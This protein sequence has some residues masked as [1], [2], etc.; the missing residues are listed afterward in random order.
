MSQPARVVAP[1]IVRA[2]R[3]ILRKSGPTP[4]LEVSRELIRLG[5]M[6]K[7]PA[8]GWK[9]VDTIGVMLRRDEI[10]VSAGVIYP[11]ALGKT[12]P[13]HNLLLLPQIRKMLRS[14]PMW[15][16]AAMR[17]DLRSRGRIGQ[18]GFGGRRLYHALRWLARQG[19][20]ELTAETVTAVALLPPRQ[21]A[22]PRPVC[23]LTTKREAAR[24]RASKVAERIGA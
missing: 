23:P 15:S 10:E 17:A 20:V 9:L 16:R 22:R 5:Y 18:C 3:R 13:A 2:I 14:Q 21:Y 24:R 12:K 8:E 19:E 11:L 6:A 7:A 4:R 1:S